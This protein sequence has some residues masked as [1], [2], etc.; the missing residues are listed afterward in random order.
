MLGF[1]SG[2]LQKAAPAQASRWEA[3]AVVFTEML[4]QQERWEALA[5]DEQ[6]DEDTKSRMAHNTSYQPKINC[7]LSTASGFLLL[8]GTGRERHPRTVAE[9]WSLA[10]SSEDLAQAEL[11]FNDLVLLPGEPRETQ[12]WTRD[13]SG[14]GKLGAG[15]VSTGANPTLHSPERQRLGS[16]TRNGGKRHQR[17]LA[18]GD[19]AST[20]PQKGQTRPCLKRLLQHVAAGAPGQK[21]RL[22]WEDKGVLSF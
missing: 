11:P 16:I 8:A 15:F 21:A 4:G 7:C 13:S 17:R 10:P 1:Y 5:E 19:R 6:H 12:G 3:S 2:H 20:R 9:R 22:H 14:W 18:E